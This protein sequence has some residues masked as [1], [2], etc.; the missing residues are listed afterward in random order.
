ML[1]VRLGSDLCMSALLYLSCSALFYG[2]Y[3][4]ACVHAGCANAVSTVF[5]PVSAH[6]FLYYIRLCND[7]AT[8]ASCPVKCSCFVFSA[9]AH[10][11]GTCYR[12]SSCEP[13]HCDA[14]SRPSPPF[15]FL[16]WVF[17]LACSF[18]LSPRSFFPHLADRRSSHLPTPPAPTARHAYPAVKP[19]HVLL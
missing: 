11:L 19:C 14:A 4:R 3:T 18:F 15:C 7:M 1:K 6:H 17:F 2:S 8:D 12:R 5:S 16:D 10:G 13:A 9:G